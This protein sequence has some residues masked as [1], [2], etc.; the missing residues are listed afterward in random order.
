MLPPHLSML[1]ILV[2]AV[3]DGVAGQPVVYNVFS[4]AHDRKDVDLGMK[5]LVCILEHCAD[6]LEIA[7]TE[8]TG[9]RLTTAPVAG[10]VTE[11][12]ERWVLVA[13]YD[14]FGLADCNPRVM[15]ATNSLLAHYPERLDTI[16]M[17][18]APWVRMIPTSCDFFS[19]G[20][21][22]YGRAQRISPASSR[23]CTL[24]YSMWIDLHNSDDFVYAAGVLGSME[25]GHTILEGVDEK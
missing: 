6:A 18:D 9:T 5:H 20:T 7:A 10:A 23:D 15:M 11:R 19:A 12:C 21:L 14:G 3:V 24:L 22:L 2:H 4:Q 25:D 16:I 17:V 8:A 1:T 13:D